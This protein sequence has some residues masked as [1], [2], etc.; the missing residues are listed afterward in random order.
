[1]AVLSNN[2][3]GKSSVR[4]VKVVRTADRHE[5]KDIIVDIQFTGAFDKVYLDGDNRNVLPTDTMKNTVY[6]L[7]KKHPLRTVEEFGLALAE[8]FIR[9][10]PDLSKV[11]LDLIENMWNR[12]PVSSASGAP[13]PHP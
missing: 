13:S 4:L 8:H 7:A 10:N 2:S 5:L 1:M 9:N 11:T 12:I 6:A 3:Y